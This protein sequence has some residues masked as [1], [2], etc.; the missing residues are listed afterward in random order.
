[1]NYNKRQIIAL[2]KKFVWHPFTQMADWL[3]DS[4]AEPLVIERGS[5]SYLIDI[6]GRKYLDGVSSLWVTVHGHRKKEI[7]GAVK[8]QLGKIAH[9][10]FL[11]LTHP[12]AALLAR[13]LAGILPEGLEKVFYS[14]NGSTAVEVALKMAYQ[15]SARSGRKTAFLSLRNA[16]HGD[17]IGSVS[18]GGMDLFHEKFRSLLFKTYFAMSPYCYRCA[19]RAGKGPLP[20][21]GKGTD[22]AGHCKAMGCR[23]RCVK[24]LEDLLKKHSDKICAAVVEPM[25]QGAAGML[26]MPP[27]Y[28]KLFEKLCRKYGV[29]LICDEVATGFGRTG[30]MFA[31]EHE[32]VKPDFI[33]LSKGITG[34]YLPL[35][36]TVTTKKVYN[37]FLGKYEDFKTFFHGHT[38][39]ANPLACAAALANLEL[40]EKEKLLPSL[41]GKAEF[42]GEELS[43]LRGHRNV[44]DIRQLG[45]MA[46]IEIVKDKAAGKIFAPEEKLTIKICDECR[47]RG[48]I[49]RPLGNVLVLMPPLSIN[50][51][52]I[53]KM[54]GLLFAALRAV[55]K[56]DETQKN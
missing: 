12:G 36:V 38:Y 29:L 2:D 55:L 51:S 11:G 9:T 21:S 39:T 45:L 53:S 49:I 25:I 30:K 54:T 32:G 44:G 6:D 31:V 17:T 27:G 14:D 1:M 18:V 3:R 33:C 35:A 43:K 40:F 22:F 37:A 41:K 48:L 28:L 47:R 26:T 23:G 24:E 42:L 10:T 20:E 46:G 34:G 5:G 52:E 50:K 4:P 13:E 8:R 7:D 19:F 56:D 16:Y 15:Y